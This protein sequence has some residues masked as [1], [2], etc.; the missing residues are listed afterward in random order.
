M[1]SQDA[2]EGGIAVRFLPKVCHWIKAVQQGY[3]E[4]IK[5]KNARM[6]KFLKHSVYVGG[7][8]AP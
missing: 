6:L 8:R 5:S 3:R 1:C 2:P 7:L 4:M